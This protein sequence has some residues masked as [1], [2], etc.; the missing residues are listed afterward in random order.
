VDLLAPEGQEIKL[1]AGIRDRQL[2]SFS[3]TRFQN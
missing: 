3:S 2:V 1:L